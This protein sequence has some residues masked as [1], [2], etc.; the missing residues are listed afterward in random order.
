[1]SHSEQNDELSALIFI[2]PEELE[3]DE[4][5]KVVR[6]S[7]TRDSGLLLCTFHLPKTYPDSSAPVLEL[8]GAV[9][10]EDAS[11]AEQELS[12]LYRPG[13]R[14]YPLCRGRGS[15]ADAKK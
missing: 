4:V 11:W 15:D 13:K 5:G 7:I 10:K 8:S 6:I 2:Y 3:V 14:S 12:A 9:S 1:M